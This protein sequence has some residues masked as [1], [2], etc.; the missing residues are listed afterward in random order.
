MRIDPVF[1]LKSTGTHA[2]YRRAQKFGSGELVDRGAVTY[3]EA[4]FKL[5][6]A[7][8]I[9]V[10]DIVKNLVNFIRNGGVFGIGGSKIPV[11]KSGKKDVYAVNAVHSRRSVDKYIE[12]YHRSHH[13]RHNKAGTK[14]LSARKPPQKDGNTA[15]C[16]TKIRS[17]RARRYDI[18]PKDQYHRT[19]P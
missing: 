9:T 11:L 18:D 13:R 8:G 7:S 19:A 15:E 6:L 10:Q 17:A 12:N 4:G 5:K 16:G 2:A 3:A 1:C 14:P